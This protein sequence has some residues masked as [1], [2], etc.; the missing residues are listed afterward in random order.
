MFD[1]RIE[2]S[3]QFVHAS[4]ERDF[5]SLAFISQP[6]VKVADHRITS[7]GHQGRHIEHGPYGST[8]TPDTSPTSEGPAVAIE[9]SDAHQRCDLFAVES[10]E[11]RQLGEKR[12]ADHWTDAGDASEQVFIFAPDRALTDAMVEVLVGPVQLCFQ[13]TDV[14]LDPF[15]DRFRSCTQSVFLRHHHLDELSSAGDE[16]SQ[17]QADL[18]GQG[19]QGRTYDFGEAGQHFG[20]DT[21]GLGQLSEGFG[22]VSDLPWIDHDDGELSTAQSPADTTFQSSG[23]LQHDQN[24]LKFAQSFDQSLDT[25]FVVRNRQ[26]YFTASIPASS[27]ET[28]S[29]SADGRIATSSRALDTSIP[30][31][32]GSIS[33]PQSSL[34]LLSSG[35]AQPCE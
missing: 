18:I 7:A 31:N 6:F 11:F 12:T 23:G 26:N 30:I 19:T 29:F 15:S 4:D 35:T 32:M 9:R 28:D 13:P 34:I 16:R 22:E 2:N 33:K 10:S 8:S 24:G 17:F 3:E 5:R 27:F 25:G 1:H 20:I 21:V 14:S